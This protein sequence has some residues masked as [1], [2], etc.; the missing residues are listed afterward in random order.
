MVRQVIPSLFRKR[1]E[2]ARKSGGEREF[3]RQDPEIRPA[4]L[5]RME[6][7][8]REELQRS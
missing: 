6:K 3:N 7:A 5:R 4:E 2:S 8:A 1:F